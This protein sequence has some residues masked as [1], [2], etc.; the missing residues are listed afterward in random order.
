MP[1]DKTVSIKRQV[2]GL[3]TVF[4]LSF[5][6]ETRGVLLVFASCVARGNDESAKARFQS[7]LCVRRQS[8]GN[9]K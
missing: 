2:S 1:I 5:C 3:A 6:V 9:L 7:P 4:S 8:D